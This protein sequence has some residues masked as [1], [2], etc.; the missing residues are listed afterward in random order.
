MKIIEVKERTALL[1]EQLT[2]V[3]ERSVKDTHLFLS[4]SEIEDIKNM[5]HKR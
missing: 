3:W 5:S 2:E 4:E 1:I